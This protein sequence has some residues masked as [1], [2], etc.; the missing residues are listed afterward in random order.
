MPLTEGILRMPVNTTYPGVY[1][2]ELPS[3]IRTIIGVPTSTAAFVGLAERGPAKA[4]HITSWSDFERTFGGLSPSSQ[5]SYAVYHFYLNGGAEAEI[6]RVTRSDAAPSDL[7][8]DGV[9]MHAMSTGTWGNSLRARVDYDTAEPAGTTLYNLTVRDTATGAE[10]RYLN[11]SIDQ[12]SPRRLDK[13]LTSSRLLT[14]GANA[15]LG[16]RPKANKKP[17]TPGADSF[18]GGP[19]APATP[20]DDRFF[21]QGSGGKSGVAALGKADV[22]GDPVAKT[23]MNS[24][25]DTDIFNLLCIPPLVAGTDLPAGT[26]DDA[27]RLCVDRRA[28]LLVDPPI[29]WTTIDAA[30][31]GTFPVQGSDAKNAALYFPRIQLPDPKQGDLLADFAPCGAVAGVMARTDSQRG[32]WKAPAGIDAS[33]NGVRGLTVTMTDLENGRLNPRGV[34]CIRNFPNI[35]TVVWGARTLRG[36]D[37]LAD[38]WKYVPVRR[39]ALYI[40]ESLFRGTKWVVFEPNDEPLWASIRLNVGAFMNSL[41]RKGAFQ[42]RTPKDAYLVKCDAENNPQQDIDRGIV[43]ILVGFAPLKPAEFVIIHIQQISPAPEV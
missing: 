38:Q 43:N 9:I 28:L 30:A 12:A 32:V 4:Y 7:D 18:A 17:A 24:L 42:G 26:L 11:V 21:T 37:V 25:L 8:L 31:T 20:A 33:V 41:Y 15:T 27:L 3:A 19:A 6:V 35:G 1:I 13:V 16:A 36:A 10:E 23:G 39:L 5:M 29:A 34:N 40:E 22:V 2:D 14:V